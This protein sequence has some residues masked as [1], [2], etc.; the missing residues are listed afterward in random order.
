MKKSRSE[1]E[2]RRRQILTMVGENGEVTVAELADRLNVSLLTVRRD[3]QYL[4]D[5]AFLERFYGGAK[6]GVN[7]KA[8]EVKNEVDVCREGIA[9]YAASLVE[10]GDSIFINTSSTVLRMLKYI[11]SKN[12]TVITNNGNA[13][14]SVCPPNVSI[15]LTGG[16]LRNRKGVMVGDFAIPNLS[17]ITAQK[18]FIGCSGVSLESG[19][20]TEAANEV[21]INEMM[22]SKVTG[23][24]FI[25]ADH[26]KIGK[27]S[28]FV[29]CP[30]E[31][32]TDVITDTR[33]PDSMAEEFKKLG[34]RLHRV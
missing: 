14:N 13:I 16:E 8:E 33:V 25:L 22:F 31:N 1:V 6:R 19:M 11:K 15:I 10:D 3:L 12:V 18:S 30:I 28:S 5:E 24:A 29:S 9:R 26:Q 2:E 21:N 27:N 4:E 17:K 7:L 20:T 32:I 23:K 34:V